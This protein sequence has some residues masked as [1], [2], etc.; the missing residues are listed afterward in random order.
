[1]GTGLD[2]FS[3][4]FRRQRNL[5]E[6]SAVSGTITISDHNYFIDLLVNGGLLLFL[7]FIIIITITIAKIYKSLTNN[8]SKS[9][10]IF[11]LIAVWLGLFI[12]ALISPNQI[13]L[14]VW[15]WVCTGLIVVLAKKLKE[16]QIEN[17]VVAFSH[18]LQNS[19]NL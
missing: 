3:E 2:T 5:S 16:P 4:S 1:M 15:F 7:S 18:K 8:S 14:M 11:I 9:P 17:K 6:I 10:R 12:Q 19:K 13:G